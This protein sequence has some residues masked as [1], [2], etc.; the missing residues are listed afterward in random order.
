M[1][2][3]RGGATWIIHASWLALVR[4]LPPTDRDSRGWHPP[5]KPAGKADRNANC[6]AKQ[7]L[8][9]RYAASWSH[10]HYPQ[11]PGIGSQKSLNQMK[12]FRS[13]CA[14]IAFVWSVTQVIVMQM[15]DRLRRNSIN[16]YR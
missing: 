2:N 16:W 6:L 12:L 5:P 3:R 4:R 13:E 14:C 15:N 7:L 1:V 9:P 10:T 8:P 11:S